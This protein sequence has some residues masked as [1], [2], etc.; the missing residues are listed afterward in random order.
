MRWPFCLGLVSGEQ[1][2]AV[3]GEQRA[4]DRRLLLLHRLRP[5]PH[6]AE[7]GQHQPGLP[8][9]EPPGEGKASPQLA[10]R[11]Q[12]WF[13]NDDLPLCNRRPT[14]TDI[15]VIELLYSA[16][17]SSELENWWRSTCDGAADPVTIESPSVYS[18]VKEI[19]LTLVRFLEDSR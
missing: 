2:A 7:A 18:G 17:C 9:D 16:L 19:S 8:G 4:G 11:T 14:I 5:D 13:V 3:H 1:D 6:P 12:T 15:I 10:G